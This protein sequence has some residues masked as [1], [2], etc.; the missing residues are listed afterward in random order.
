M[1][2]LQILYLNSDEELLANECD[3]LEK[4]PGD[5]S[6]WL[7]SPEAEFLNGRF[8]WAQWDVDELISLKEKVA[9]D[10]SYLTIS[11]VK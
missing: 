3:L 8:V 4:V 11:L 7:A 10:P 1:V 6:V 2:C 5:F 9:A